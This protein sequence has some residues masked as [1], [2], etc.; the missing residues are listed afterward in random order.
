[1]PLLAD[2]LKDTL[3]RIELWS[4]RLYLIVFAIAAP[5]G[6]SQTAAPSR[7]AVRSSEMALQS[8]IASA[9]DFS[10]EEQAFFY[11]HLAMQFQSSGRKQVAEWA[12]SGI[13][14]AGRMTPS[15][16]QQAIIKNCI[17]ALSFRD[18]DAAM[19]LLQTA[20]VRQPD[21]GGGIAEDLTA[22]AAKTVF[23][24]A[25]RAGVPVEYIKGVALALAAKG[26]YP[27][28]GMAAVLTGAKEIDPLDRRILVGEMAASFSTAL[29]AESGLLNYVE[30]IGL[31]YAGLA[32]PERE[33]LLKPLIEF[34]LSGTAASGAG[35]KVILSKGEMRDPS[36]IG[37]KLLG[38]LRLQ[39]DQVP[40]RLL[41]EWEKVRQRYGRIPDRP[42]ALAYDGSRGG[43]KL[44]DTAKQNLGERAEL[45]RLLAENPRETGSLI[46]GLQRLSS[47]DLRHRL[48]YII[49]VRDDL[50]AE[51]AELV[52]A[53]IK[54]I[55]SDAKTP[56]LRLK[57]LMQAFRSDGNCGASLL[58]DRGESALNLAD[59]LYAASEM[60]SVARPAYDHDGFNEANEVIGKLASCEEARAAGLWDGVGSRVLKAYVAVTLA[61]QSER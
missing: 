54:Q 61:A 34:L 15:W 36:V 53:E 55:E 16:N 25:Q 9:I 1:L 45:T 60:A 23:R 3:M 59:G 56:A 49:A 31:L 2:K 52:R 38:E 8:A 19:E 11:T 10:A 24:N 41:G 35:E 26:E 43:S 47:P 28:V 21:D 14:A 5:M 33:V 27:F 30:A 22:N 6:H 51:T 4:R 32:L 13:T 46:R 17:V 40:E 29:Q 37:P 20:P 12:K 18:P 48:L 50:P 58:W 42:Q 57:L 39:S 44:S 7:E